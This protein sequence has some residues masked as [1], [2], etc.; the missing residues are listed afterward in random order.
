MS[1]RC[2]SPAVAD[3]ARVA[4][5]ESG[6]GV[7]IAV[8]GDEGGEARGKGSRSVHRI[9]TAN[10]A[11]CHQ[12]PGR[13][14]DGKVERVPHDESFDVVELADCRLFTD[15]PGP[16]KEELLP[17]LDALVNLHPAGGSGG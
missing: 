15:H 13:V 6:D 3:I 14:Q 5:G 16:V 8:G 9:A 1:P 2:R 4:P 7:E 10:L 17:T 11:A 12:I